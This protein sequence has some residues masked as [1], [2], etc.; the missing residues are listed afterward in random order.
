MTEAGCL[1]ALSSFE[2]ESATARFDERTVM[3]AAAE[4]GQVWIV[5]EG[6]RS[7][8]VPELAGRLS[9]HGVRLLA[10]KREDGGVQMTRI[11]TFDD[12]RRKEAA[13]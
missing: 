7:M 11:Y 1:F 12:I 8:K 2:A 5:A 10:A 3:T 6:A 13:Q 9:E 4:T